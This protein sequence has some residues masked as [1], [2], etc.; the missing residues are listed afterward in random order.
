MVLLV[1]PARYFGALISFHRCTGPLDKKIGKKMEKNEEIS[2]F[3]ATFASLGALEKCYNLIQKPDF[4][5][6]CVLEGVLGYAN[7]FPNVC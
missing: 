3:Q 2:I 5:D 1:A 7:M 4:G 6:L